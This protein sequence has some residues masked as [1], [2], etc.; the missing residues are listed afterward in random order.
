MTLRQGIAILAGTLFGYNED[1]LKRRL[2]VETLQKAWLRHADLIQANLKGA[3][4]EGANLEAANL[5]E[6][7]LRG[8]NLRCAN[9]E[10]AIMRRANLIGAD[11][12]GADLRGASL[13]VEQL[14]EAIVDQTTQLPCRVGVSVD[15]I[16]LVRKESSA[17]ARNLGPSALP[18]QP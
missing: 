6:A 3:N 11:L 5:F 10:T 16:E 7:N 2:G 13:T 17:Q 1:R 4:L 18:P 14:A 9:L 8:A 12:R 15:S